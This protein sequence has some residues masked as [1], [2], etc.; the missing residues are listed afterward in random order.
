MRAALR[1]V[2]TL[3]RL[4]GDEFVAVL[5]D[6][7]GEGDAN[8]LVQRLL[9]ALSAPVELQGLPL[10]VTGSVG[11]TFYPQE[12]ELE[13]DQLYRREDDQHPLNG[14]VRVH[15]D[16]LKLTVGEPQWR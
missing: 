6:L 10:Q 12:E 4:G 5:S 15:L 16:A 11:V 8:A 1:D 3:A 7:S 14:T 9:E 2:D 13:A